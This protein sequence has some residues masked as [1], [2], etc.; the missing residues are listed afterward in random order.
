[1]SYQMLSGLAGFGAVAMAFNADAVWADCLAGSS[2][3]TGKEPTC[4][5][6]KRCGQSIQA[7]LNALGYGPLTVDG[8][9][10]TGTMAAIKRFSM[11]NGFGSLTW[12]TK[13]M[14]IKMGELLAA[15]EK[16][17]PGPVVESHVVNG[18]FVPGAAPGGGMSTGMSTGLALG[19]GAIALVGV[20][21]LALMAK[22]KG[23]KA[24]TTVRI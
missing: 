9:I 13:P 8:Q 19:L 3:K 12:P 16:P 11:D 17:G 24:S 7:A 23:G 15:G 1:M 5:A 21:A 10:G 2:C 14:V 6:S 18:E 4:G 20:G 22:K